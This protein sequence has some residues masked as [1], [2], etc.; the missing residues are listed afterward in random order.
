MKNGGKYNGYMKNITESG[1]QIALHSYSHNYPQVYASEQAFFDDL[2]KISDLVYNETGVRTNIFRF[3]G[4][5]S[6]TI[7]RK[8]S[9]GIMTT[10]T[11]EV[12]E[13]GYCYFDWNVSSG[14]AVS[15]EQPKNTII[16]NCK[17]VPKSN[18][19]VVLLHDSAVK[20]TTVEALPEIIAYYKSMGYSFGVL[21]E[22][23]Y[24]VHQKVNN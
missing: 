23:T 10:L 21:S 3:P 7:S 8:Y 9:P 12:Q 17:K 19:I 2:Q 6:N 24:P 22:K 5:S 18:T 14:D 20:N 13:K 16:E 11:K 15:R 4:G 1:N